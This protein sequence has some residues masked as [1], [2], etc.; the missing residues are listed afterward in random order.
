ME[1]SLHVS[2]YGFALSSGR[3]RFESCPVTAFLTMNLF[4]YYGL[5]SKYGG[6]SGIGHQAINPICCAK[7]DFLPNKALGHE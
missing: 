5:C 6:S 3:S 4:I 2:S 7:T 1:N